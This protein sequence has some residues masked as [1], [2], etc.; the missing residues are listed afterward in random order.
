MGLL[1][2]AF[3]MIGTGATAQPQA[4]RGS[5]IYRCGNTYSQIPCE[6][7]RTLE[8]AAPSS[9]QKAREAQAQTDRIQRRADAMAHER[10]RLEDRAS[11]QR[12]AIFEHPQ[13]Q[14]TTSRV[15]DARLHKPHAPKHQ[16]VGGD[17]TA[18]GAGE[19]PAGKKKKKK[20]VD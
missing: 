9:A 10:E 1:A 14:S 3:A 6:N 5:T 16:T 8:E 18:R 4:A 20:R 12:P 7:G 19:G 11:G 17:F 15:D 13:R 2:L